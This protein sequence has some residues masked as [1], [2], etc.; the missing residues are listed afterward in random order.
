MTQGEGA[1]SRG[2]AT[3]LYDCARQAAV[4]NRPNC[5]IALRAGEYE[6]REGEGLVEA[7][8]EG[9]TIQNY[10]G[11]AV[12]LSGGVA[13]TVATERWKP[14][15]LEREWVVAR[16]QNVVYG[17]V[18]SRSNASAIMYVGDFETSKECETAAKVTRDARSWT[19]HDPAFEGDF[20]TQCF[21]RTDDT[22][23]CGA[24]N[25]LAPFVT[26]RPPTR[27]AALQ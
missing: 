17:Q 6:V 16:A 5:T 8:H 18:A 23:A 20:A 26:R 10:E 2:C 15:V 9:L 21:V 7:R 13:F 11:E 22:P 4:A 25:T 27:A 24:W 12:T 3:V 14:H 19:H 1:L